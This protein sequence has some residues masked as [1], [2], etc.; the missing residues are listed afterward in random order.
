MAKKQYDWQQA[1][2]RPPT[3]DIVA[4]TTEEELSQRLKALREE[5]GLS[6]AEL[7]E[8]A[9]AAGVPLTRAS[10][11]YME[12]G[13]LRPTPRI[14]AGIAPHLG[15]DRH[16]VLRQWG[17]TWASTLTPSLPPPSAE[18]WLD[19]LSAV[20]SLGNLPAPV[21]NAIIGLAA[22]YP[23]EPRGGEDR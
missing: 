6:Q 10:I 17:P 19:Q 21:F 8:R 9:T 4:C 13:T 22:A 14:L 16:T 3:T 12:N 2:A 11:S 18:A 1:R 20:L 7:A 23:P 5:H 15:L